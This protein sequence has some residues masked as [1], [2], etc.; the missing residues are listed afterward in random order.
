M[1]TLLLLSMVA[2]FGTAAMADL[3]LAQDGRSEY[4]IVIAAD[5]IPSERYAAEQLQ[6]YLERMSGAKLPVV[7]DTEAMAA[8]EIMVGDSW[9]AREL[10]PDP[11][12]ADLGPDGFVLRAD[13]GHLLIVGD[14]PRGTL[15]GVYT[16]LEEKLGVRWFTPELE[17]VPRLERVSLADLNETQV[18]ALENRDVFWREMMRDADFAAKHRL[19]GQHYGLKE[20]HGGAFTRYHP[21]VHSFDMLVPPELFKDHPEYFPM[22]DGKRKGGYVQR[23]LSH[24]DVLKLSIEKVKQWIREHPNANI[25]SVS[26]NDTIDNCHCPECKAVDDAEGTPAGS[27]LKYVNAIAEAI[28]KDHPNVRIDTLAYQY[29]RKAPKTIRP[30]RNVIV[31]LCSIECCFAHPLESC[32]AEANRAFRDDIIAWEP[33]APLLYVW[34]YTPN[35]AHYQQPFPNFDSLQPNVRF[36]VNHGVKSLFEQG[37]YSGGGYGELGPLRAYVLAKLL[38]NPDTDVQKHI[39]EFLGAYYGAAAG[40]MKEYLELATAQVRGKDCHAHIFDPPSACYLNDAF[41]READRILTNAE[42]RA[43]DDAVRS[44]VEVARLPIWY[45][46]IVK[47]RVQGE[48]RTALIRRFLAV[49][50]GTGVSNISEGMALEAWA[51]KMKAD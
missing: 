23:C 22:I 31:R 13:G 51:K 4:R 12:L 42:K 49:A 5:A 45:V 46:Q 7:E 32:P 17:K 30:H 6:Q 11:R 8:H 15:N 27:L 34:D 20:K 44:R 21:F 28:E 33:V 24:P 50:R 35:F 40:S 2:A 41:L 26:Q 10:L 36:F 29:T 47:D 16:L 25:I 38:W 18:P 14:K 3:N 48:E 1:R 37:N 19:N 43:E 9:H 39:D